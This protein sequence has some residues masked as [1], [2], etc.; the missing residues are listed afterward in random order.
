MFTTCYRFR[1]ILTNI[2][3]M[4]DTGADGDLDA[5]YCLDAPFILA[6]GSIAKTPEGTVVSQIL[7]RNEVQ[8]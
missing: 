8:Q 4:R 2:G 6:A 3:N 5:G 7:L 1:T